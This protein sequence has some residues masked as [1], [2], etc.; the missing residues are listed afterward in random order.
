MHLFTSF[1]VSYL[2][3]FLPICSVCFIFLP[4]LASN[5]YKM[6]INIASYLEDTRKIVCP[7]FLDLLSRYCGKRRCRN[8]YFPS[9]SLRSSKLTLL[10]GGWGI[11]VWESVTRVGK[12]VR[13]YL[14]ASQKAICHQIMQ[15]QIMD[16]S[17]Q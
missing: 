14:G 5:Y 8:F 13:K 17:L 16:P 10:R 15:H 11:A 1:P 9:S 7:A 3:C 6:P 12:L 2:V 4:A